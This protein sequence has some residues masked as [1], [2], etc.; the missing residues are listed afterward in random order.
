MDPA[1]AVRVAY[2]QQHTAGPIIVPA[3]THIIYIGIQITRQ[4]IRIRVE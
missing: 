2:I 4:V 3:H 1:H